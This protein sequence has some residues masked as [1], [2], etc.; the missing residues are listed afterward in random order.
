MAGHAA[1]IKTTSIHVTFLYSA[2]KER[3]QFETRRRSDES[4]NMSL[5]GIESEDVD[6]VRLEQD[7]N[8]CYAL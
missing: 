4:I 7:T 5:K 6:R 2:Q 3:G 8:P 1:R